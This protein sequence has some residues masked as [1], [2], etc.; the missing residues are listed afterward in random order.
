[1]RSTLS[2]LWILS[3]MIVALVLGACGGGAGSDDAA[4][5]AEAPVVRARSAAPTMPA[6]QFAAPTSIVDVT[7]VAET[8]ATPDANEPDLDLGASA[9]ARLC[10]ECHGEAGEGV[11]D[12]GSAV[13]GLGLSEADVTDLLR[14]GGG[15]GNE[16][17]FGPSKISEDGIAGLTAFMATL[18]Q[19]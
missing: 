5:D 8:A 2:Y 19:D 9:Y 7:K 11:A 17:I 15:F 14:T 4:T 18:G 12:K 3:L 1:M 16:H 10:A 6:A 13:V